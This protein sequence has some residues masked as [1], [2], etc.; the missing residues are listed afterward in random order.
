MTLQKS[1]HELSEKEGKSVE[2][3]LQDANSAAVYVENLEEFVR[4]RTKVEITHLKTKLNFKNKEVLDSGCGPGRL[5]LIFARYA[6]KVTGIDFSQSFINIAERERRNKGIIN[7]EFKCVSVLNMDDIIPEKEKFDIIF[8]GGVLCCMTDEEAKQSLRILSNRLKDKNALLVLREPIQYNNT[9][10]VFDENIK[11][12]HED[13]IALTRD[14]NLEMV[15]TKETFFICPFYKYY[16]KIDKDRRKK[17]F[18]KYLFRVLFH[19]NVW[20]DAIV[21]LFGNFYLKHFTKKW[22]VQQKFYIFRYDTDN[23]G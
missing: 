15:Y 19:I 3:G 2:Y 10:Q 4:F 1:I 13:F 12:T 9:T 22:T 16:L 23:T 14:L 8:Q 7:V 5:S 21:R 18:N 11:R 20:I 17:K 6:K